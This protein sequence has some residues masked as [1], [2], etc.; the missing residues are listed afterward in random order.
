MATRICSLCGTEYDE[1]RAVCT[2]CGEP[3]DAGHESSPRPSGT[4][5]RKIVAGVIL[6]AIALIAMMAL[7][8]SRGE[9]ARVALAAPDAPVARTDA[10]PTALVPPDDPASIPAEERAFLDEIAKGRLAY[11]AGRFDEALAEFTRA[12]ENN[13]ANAQAAGDAAQV[14]AR[15]N[16]YDEAVPLLRD[17][18]RVAPTRWDFR[19]NLGRA[20]AQSGQYEDAVTEYREASRLR[21]DSY[22]TVFNLAQTLEKLGKDEEALAEYRRGT[23]LAPLEPSFRLAV[24]NLSERQQKWADA[25]KAYEE[26]L[27][28][29]PDGAESARVRQHLGAVEQRAGQSVAAQQTPVP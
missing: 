25:K 6:A 11:N 21:P 3:P 23:E 22:P 29:V 7:P 16:R 5:T 14:L 10:S 8:R 28:L 9:R 13:R 2:R 18:V 4:N 20:L 12:F 1:G 24:G 17:A 26:Y 19:F 27:E 15:L